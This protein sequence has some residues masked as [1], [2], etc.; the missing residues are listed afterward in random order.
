MSSV[1]D[2]Q[3]DS[4]VFGKLTFYSL[5][6]IIKANLASFPGLFSEIYVKFES[7]K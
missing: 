2:I 3:S 4:S 7:K 1:C 6:F 5:Q